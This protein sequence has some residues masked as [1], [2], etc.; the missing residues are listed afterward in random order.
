MTL[1][2]SSLSSRCVRRSCGSRNAEECTQKECPNGTSGRPPP[3]SMSAY[4]SPPRVLRTSR[5][6]R[7][8]RFAVIQRANLTDQKNSCQFVV[9][10]ET[11]ARKKFVSICV[12]L[13]SKKKYFVFVKNLCQFVSIC[14]RKKVLRVRKKFVSICVN[15]CS[16]KEYFVFVKSTSWQ[17]LSAES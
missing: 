1:K 3:G 17:L 13:C 16:K 14:V 8:D 7:G 6:L 15:L 12:N 2:A 11:R 5:L 9:E 10:K 4:S